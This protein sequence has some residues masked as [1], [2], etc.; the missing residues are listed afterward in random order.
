MK[1]IFYLV[2]ILTVTAGS[3]AA[4]QKIT[5]NVK[6]ET[7]YDKILPSE[8]IYEYKD[9]QPGKL[10]Y[11]GGN[12]VK[13]NF[14]YNLSTKALL[15]KDKSDRILEFAFPDQIKMVM[16]DSTYWVPLKGGLGK[17]VYNRDSLDLVKYRETVCTDIRK[18]GAFGGMSNTSAITNISSIQ[19]SGSS[20]M[21]LAVKGEYDF[22]TKV[23]YFLKIGDKIEYADAKGF[24]KLFPRQKNEINSL[25]KSRKLNLDEESD[26]IELIKI[27]T[28][29]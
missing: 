9:F 26:I 7:E 27:L 3:V 11:T 8:M 14:N 20:R 10:Y 24:R 6:T 12:V 13:H 17:I 19:G 2:F 28:F 1:K 25:I 15:F 5:V 16:I 22:E 4:Q 23:S 29:K 21:V 18:E